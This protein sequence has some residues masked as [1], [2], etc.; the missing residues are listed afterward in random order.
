[1]NV[2]R[3]FIY[4][5]AVTIAVLALVF[6]LL[7]AGLSSVIQPQPSYEKI[8][9]PTVGD[10]QRLKNIIISANSATNHDGTQQLMLSDRDINLVINQFAPTIREIP[11]TTVI[12]NLIE[13]GKFY[14]LVSAPADQVLQSSKH[15][16]D[17]S[18]SQWY[19]K[20]KTQIDDFVANK[21]INLRLLISIPISTKTPQLDEITIG[22]F[23]LSPSI[24][25]RIQA[26]IEQ[27]ISQNPQAALLYASW[28]NIQLIEVR[29][30]Q[31]DLR[32]TIPEEQNQQQL[33]SLQNLLVSES[34]QQ[35]VDAYFSAISSFKKGG[36][37][38]DTVSQLFNLAFEKSQ[39]SLDPVAENRAALLALSRFYGGDKILALAQRGD[40]AGISRFRSHHSIFGRKDLAQHYVLSAGLT[41][42]TSKTLSDFA[43]LE[44]ELFDLDQRRVFSLWDLAADKAGARLAEVAT[45]SQKN[46]KRVQQRLKNARRENMLMPDLS[47]EIEELGDNFDRSEIDQ[48]IELIDIYLDQHQLL[49]TR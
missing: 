25:A 27:E 26:S 17:E 29:E 9:P 18:A 48:V 37:L 1:M 30:E 28:E 10:L 31:L 21:W 36:R 23:D 33:S 20:F 35:K 32:F 8:E 49:R 42:L 6:F 43:G 13:D 40:I 41:V 5:L 39:Q 47:S 14:L 45:S 2:I 12:R 24:V 46:A 16:L 38:I 11:E 22:H 7:S 15:Y 4:F 3:K 44:K 19:L 34:E